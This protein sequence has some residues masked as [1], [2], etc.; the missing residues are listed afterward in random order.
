MYLGITV[1][2][3]Y[4]DEKYFKEDMETENEDDKETENEENKNDKNNDEP[5]VGMYN[6]CI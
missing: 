1:E 5:T 2:I 6:H 3:Y 4:D